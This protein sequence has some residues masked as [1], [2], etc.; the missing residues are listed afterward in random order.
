FHRFQ[1]FLSVV[2]TLYHSVVNEQYLATNQYAVTTYEQDVSPQ[3]VPGVFFKF[4]VEPV[5][6]A[7]TD[8]RMGLLL[9]LVRL[10]NI[11]GGVFVSGG[12]IYKAYDKLVRTVRGQG[13][14]GLNGRAK[15]DGMLHGRAEK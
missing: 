13:R 5:T 9:F 12:W 14:P 3:A 2:P 15:S 11:A 4:D 10:V 6:L 7:I 8:R 1:Y